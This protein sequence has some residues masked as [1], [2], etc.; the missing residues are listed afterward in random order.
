[1][2][3][4]SGSS[5]AQ[6]AYEPFGNTTVT[7]GGSTNPFQFTGRENDGTG[8]YFYR[9]RY[10]SPKFQ[11]FV[12]ED[13]AGMAGGFNLYAYT[14]ND[15]INFSDSLGLQSFP[16]F[17]GGA[18]GGGGAGGSWG[19]SGGSG[20]SDGGGPGGS[21][22]SGGGSGASSAA[23]ADAAAAAAAATAG[24]GAAGYGVAAASDA[25]DAAVFAVG[26]NNPGA[27][28][29]AAQVLQGLNVTVAI[30]ANGWVDYVFW[31]IGVIIDLPW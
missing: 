11:R 13:P 12:S 22:G 17:G 25:F 27:I 23:N 29:A 2:T 26:A 1:L 8:V 3:N 5:L 7:S 24:V 10:Y 28:L 20:G 16:G 15:P 18:F 30:A 9:G 14:A 6:Y 19:D 31:T 4:S 21:G